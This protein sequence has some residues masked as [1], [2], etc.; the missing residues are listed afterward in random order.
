MSKLRPKL[1][2]V[3]ILVLGFWLI[4]GNE[5]RFANQC[6]AFDQRALVLSGWSAR[7]SCVSWFYGDEV[8]NQYK[9]FL[10]PCELTMKLVPEDIE[11]A[12]KF[13]AQLDELKTVHISAEYVQIPDEIIE[14]L[15]LQHLESVSISSS[16]L[17][18]EAWK[19][20]RHAASLKRLVLDDNELTDDELTSFIGGLSAL[21]TLMLFGNRVSEQSVESICLLPALSEL[22]IEDCDFSKSALHELRRRLSNAS[23]FVNGSSEF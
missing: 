18:P 2:I 20:L 12:A 23:I 13:I 15:P 11:A 6:G 17:S 16:H 8:A 22:W 3:I 21:K 5:F 4:S 7:L 10:R 1:M 19:L 9:P 14:S